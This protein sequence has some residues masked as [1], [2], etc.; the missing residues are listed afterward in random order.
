MIDDTTA[1][2]SKLRT[3]AP[4]SRGAGDAPRARLLVL[5]PRYPYPVIGGDRLRIHRV[6]RT[7]ARHYDLT[8]L[9][10]CDDRREL[11]HQPD[12]GVFSRIERV[13]LPRWRSIANVVAALPKP[14]PL[15]VAYYRDE[16]FRRLLA[17]L[18]PQHDAAL[19]HLIRTG[20]YLIGADRPTF[21][22]MTDAISLN[23]ERVRT[24]RSRG[25]LRGLVYAFEARRLKRYERDILG[26]F[27]AVSLVSSVDR[28]F[29]LGGAIDDRVLVCSN[30]TDLDALRWRPPGR[31]P[32]LAFIGNMSSMQNL[33]ACRHFAI[34]VLP[35]LRARW[36]MR[37]RVIGRIRERDAASLRAIE[38][39]EVTGEVDDVGAALGGA[40][41]GICSVRLGA[42]VQNKVLEYM[43][44]GLPVVTTTVGLEGLGATPRE[45][46]LV[47]DTPAQ[48]E[49]RIA[50]LVEHRELAVRL[51]IAG[52]L[53]IERRPGW[54][55]LLAPL[56]ERIELALGHEPQ[57]ISRDRVNVRPVD[58]VRDRAV[59]LG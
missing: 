5:T 22:E 1:M 26:R 6:C 46:L 21:L 54:D 29:L 38:G 4:E 7:L 57:R 53:F 39:V 56:L 11:G 40:L 32:L 42:G 18:L 8:L 12:D 13:Y 19:A 48:F 27:D 47:A 44:L 58:A 10:L 30:G 23:Y 35:R 36:P 3:T 15:Q 25:G 17:E 24:T 49:E 59:A 2:P 50:E 37:F 16:R 14:V 41:A 51:S 45:H 20:D 43:A 52:R 31:Q 28:D 55:E 34:D 33:D 9:S